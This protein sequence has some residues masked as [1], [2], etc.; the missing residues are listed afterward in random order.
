MHQEVQALGVDMRMLV[1]ADVAEGEDDALPRI[2]NRVLNLLQH[3]SC[4]QL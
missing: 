1:A 3:T 2:H 4:S